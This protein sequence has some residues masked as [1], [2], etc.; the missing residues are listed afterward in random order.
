MDLKQGYLMSFAS[1]MDM[2][3]LPPQEEDGVRNY[4]N[5]VKELLDDGDL[6]ISRINDAVRRILAV[7]LTM[8][9]IDVPDSLAAKY[10]YTS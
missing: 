9:L 2:V 1:G 10:N 7:K 4:F 6:K 8:H 5:I 3:M